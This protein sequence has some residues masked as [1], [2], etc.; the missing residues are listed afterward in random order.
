MA[1]AAFQRGDLDGLAGKLLEVPIDL[2]ES[3]VHEEFQQGTVTA[4]HVGDT[5]CIFLTGLYQAERGIAEQIQR[6]KQ[7]ELP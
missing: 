2:I 4:N 3:A 1:I 6:I 7:G 5:D